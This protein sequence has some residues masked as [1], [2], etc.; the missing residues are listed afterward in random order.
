MNDTTFPR[1]AGKTT[2]SHLARAA[3]MEGHSFEYHLVASTAEAAAGRQAFYLGCGRV[4]DLGHALHV[5]NHGR[6]H[7]LDESITPCLEGQDN[8]VDPVLEKRQSLDW[9]RFLRPLDDYY[10]LQVGTSAPL[11][12]S[13]SGKVVDE[14]EE[15]DRAITCHRRH[16][17]STLKQTVEEE[18]RP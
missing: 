5:R 3:D 18:S 4:F 2:E 14:L 13:G 7:D 8:W 17:K 10:E 6:P 15:N 12:G 16:S 9:E 11:E 1:V